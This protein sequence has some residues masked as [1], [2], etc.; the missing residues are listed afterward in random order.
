MYI[1]V[2]PI[3]LATQTLVFNRF[4]RT[5]ALANFD[6]SDNRVTRLRLHCL[7]KHGERKIE[8]EGEGNGTADPTAVCFIA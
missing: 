3:G 4:A 6:C 8:G 5:S 7:M 2:R 1:L